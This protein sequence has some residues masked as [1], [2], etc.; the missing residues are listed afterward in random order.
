MK[1]LGFFF[2]LLVLIQLVGCSQD[3]APKSSHTP[4]L[5]SVVEQDSPAL[6]NYAAY[7]DLRAYTDLSH[8]VETAQA[9]DAALAIFLYTPNQETL[10]AAQAAWRNA[11][12]A[13]L[14]TLMYAKLPVHEP[15]E[16]RRENKSYAQLLLLIDTWPIEGGYVDHVPGY[17]FSG[18][19]N[20]LTLQINADTLLNQHGFADQSYASLGF[21]VIEFML[22]GQEGTRT[23][24]DFSPQDNT[25]PVIDENPQ[26]EAQNRLLVENVD[27]LN[28]KVQNHHRRRQFIQLVSEQLQKH[29]QQLQQRWEPSKGYYAQQWQATTPKQKVSALLQ[30]T[31]LLISDEILAKRLTA[32][33]SEFSQTSVQ[34]SLAI[35]AGIQSLL[36]TAGQPNLSTILPNE[37]TAQLTQQWQDNYAE[38]EHCHQ[39]WQQGE[40]RP[41]EARQQCHK[42]FIERLLVLQKTAD[43]LAISLPNI[44]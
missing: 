20:D 32:T 44:N 8:A 9:L 3:P 10:T 25:A 5:K 4:A 31:Q 16:W 13:F 39:Q 12:D 22:W 36:L 35:H 30:A 1:A 41:Q 17:P 23:P 19:V 29:L 42:I 27:E 33:S 38:I 15:A 37:E 6:S 24:S 34:D 43:A 2:S 21:H 40:L 14:R 18:I 28:I 11:Y 26:A 7:L